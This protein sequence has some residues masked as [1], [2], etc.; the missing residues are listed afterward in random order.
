MLDRQFR[1]YL[2]EVNTNPC[3]ET[4][5]PLLSRLIP[6]MLD[7]ALKQLLPSQLKRRLGLDPLFPPVELQLTGK[8]MPLTDIL[9]E[10]KFQ[11]VFDE[12][13]DAPQLA[14]YCVLCRSNG[15]TST[16]VVYA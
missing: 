14:D 13:I 15:L 12:R 4:S 9:P 3:L 7:S 2:I 5:C 11:L 1:V 8:R 10:N 6:T 16:D